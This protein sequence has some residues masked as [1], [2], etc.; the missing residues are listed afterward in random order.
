MV[1]KFSRFKILALETSCDETAAAVV[2]TNS[3]KVEILSSQV[4]SQIALHQKYGGVVPELAARAH[5]E[6][7]IPAVEESLRTA[8]LTP[9]RLTGLAV[10]SGPGLITSL[11]VGV[12]TAK[13]L[14]LAWQKPLLAVNHIYAHLAA[15]F[16]KPIKFPALCL[17]VSGGHTELIFLK[18]FWSCRKIGRTVDDAAGEA[19]DKVAKLLDLGYPGGPVI[20]RL[21]AVGDSE[22]Y[23]F[24]RPMLTADNFNFS[25]SGLKTAVLYQTKK[26]GRL[27]PGIKKDIAAGFQ[28]AV[29]EVLTAKTLKAAEKFKVK[30]IALAGGVAANQEL[31]KSLEAGAVEAGFEFFAPELKFCTDNAAMVGV[32]ACYLEQKKQT[33][34]NNWRKIAADPNWEL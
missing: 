27:T 28:R 12:E 34:K 24:P 15:N 3:N 1:K 19:F 7:V 10:V 20:A 31:R 21:A 22:R 29:V 23:C 25:F 33:L 30:T 11:M 14:A 5:L 4:S 32:A 17:V 16:L 18:D 26:L 6:A 2:G 8:G 13:A 9:E